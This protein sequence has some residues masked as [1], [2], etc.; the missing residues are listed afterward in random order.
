MFIARVSKGRTVRE[1]L[2]CVL[3]IPTIVSILWL[4]TFGGAAVDQVVKQAGSLE[5]AIVTQASPT[6]EDPQATT[7]VYNSELAKQ[8]NDGYAKAMFTMFESG[9]PLSG[10]LSLSV[11][12]W[13]SYF[14]SPPLTQDHWWSIQL[15]PGV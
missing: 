8:V 11:F 9:F 14:L 5:N 4:S 6:A 10:L 13:S 15:P 3:I 2:T 1:F 7:T 12:C